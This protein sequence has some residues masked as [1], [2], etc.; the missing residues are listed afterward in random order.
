MPIKASPERRAAFLVECHNFAIDDRALGRQQLQ[1]VEQLRI[2]ND[3][4]TTPDFSVGE[5]HVLI[6][7]GTGGI[8]GAFAKAFLDHGAHAI[9]ADIA[10]PKDGTDP[11]IRYE[12]LDVRDDAAVEALA[13]RVSQLDV[14]IH[15]AGRVAPLEEYRTDVFKDILDI[16]LVG[17]FAAR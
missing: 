2:G 13:V 5:K 11:R 12:Q 8:G 4:A 6:T 17:K 7:G 10:A 16:H 1:G 15:C 9:V 3:L 14:L